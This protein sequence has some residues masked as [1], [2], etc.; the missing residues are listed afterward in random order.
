MNGEKREKAKVL[1]REGGLVWFRENCE[2]G[3]VSGGR[4]FS[5]VGSHDRNNMG[6]GDTEKGKRGYVHHV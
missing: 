2:L 1:E 3:G 5:I 6:D 4:R